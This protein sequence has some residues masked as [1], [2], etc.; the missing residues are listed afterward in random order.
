MSREDTGYP[1]MTLNANTYANVTPEGPPR[2][3][4]CHTGVNESTL[5]TMKPI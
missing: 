1:L 4:E 2:A 3:N 5:T